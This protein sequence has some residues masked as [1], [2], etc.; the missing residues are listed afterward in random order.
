VKFKKQD[1]K[2]RK[3]KREISLKLFIL[4]LSDLLGKLTFII[5]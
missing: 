5:K 4:K 1:M 3:M 2:S